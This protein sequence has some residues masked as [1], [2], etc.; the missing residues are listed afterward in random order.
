MGW[1][2]SHAHILDQ[3][4][5]ADLAKTLADAKAQG[6]ERIL[7][8]ALNKAERQQVAKLSPLY[9]QLDFAAG[10]HPEDA[11]DVTDKDLLELAEDIKTGAYL[12]IGEIGLDY[13]WHSDNKEKQKQL[14]VSQLHLAREFDLPVSIHCREA[15]ADTYE[16]LK[17]A[18]LPRRGVMHCFSGDENQAR[19]FEDLGYYLAF[20][21]VITFK[22]GQQARNCARA[23][24]LSKLLIETDCPYLAPVPYRG[25]P[26]HPALVA[27]V[28]QALSELRNLPASRMQAQLEENY[29]RLFRKGI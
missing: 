16:I 24:S 6:V 17:K 9:P 28:G 18:D 25:K 8:I 23:V 21:G 2:D 13:Y 22:N 5:F 26:N 14:F 7:A 12:A 29:N 27:L 11:D 19:A 4:A 20:G 3:K 15:I 10:Y 1:I